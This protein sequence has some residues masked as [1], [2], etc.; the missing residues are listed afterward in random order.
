MLSNCVMLKSK[1]RK[2][3]NHI[4]ILFLIV[5]HFFLDSNFFLASHLA[6]LRKSFRSSITGWNEYN[7]LF[8]INSLRQQPAIS[9]C[10]YPSENKDFFIAFML[11]LIAH[12]RQANRAKSRRKSHWGN[13]VFPP[14]R[15][16]P[17]AFS[18]PISFNAIESEKVRAFRYWNLRHMMQWT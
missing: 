18:L 6:E 2:L 16:H 10:A 7:N 1:L 15:P 3:I 12:H 17:N 11:D 5:T 8:P 9:C 13:F 14:T 4:K